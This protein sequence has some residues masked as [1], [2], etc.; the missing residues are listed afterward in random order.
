M[1]VMRLC[2]ITTVLALISGG[3]TAMPSEA[4]QA[5]ELAAVIKTTKGDIRV[6]LFPAEAP[7]TV[8][9][10]VNLAQRGYYDGLKFHRVLAN[11]M[12]Q[13][14]DP[15]GT[16][17]GGPGY[18]FADEFSRSLRHDSAG[19][20]SMANAGPRTNGSQFFITHG[21]TPHLNDLHSIFGKVSSGQDI[22][23]AIAQN[24]VMTTIVIEGDAASLLAAHKEQVDE[25]NRILDGR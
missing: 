11:F 19:T 13:G 7:V 25:W 22:V 5:N 6:T 4:T 23:D 1:Q 9:N 17:S 8:A 12:I 20:L 3:P 14:G 24:D 18:Q 10:F 16:G 15:T 21:P 2:A